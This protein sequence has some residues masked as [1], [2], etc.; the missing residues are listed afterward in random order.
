[1][2]TNPGQPP[3]TTRWINPD[4]TPSLAFLQYMKSL[5]ALLIANQLGPLTNAANDAAAA[6]AGVPIGGL[7]RTINAV[8]IRLV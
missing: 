5:D 6:V 8:Q 3:S 1:M 7:Y 2:R 4:G